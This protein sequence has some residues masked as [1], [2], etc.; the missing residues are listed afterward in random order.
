MKYFFLLLM[1]AC[2]SPKS[3][4][5]IDRELQINKHKVV[6]T[7]QKAIEFN[8]R[9]QVSRNKA[10]FE[11]TELSKLVQFKNEANPDFY[12]VVE[13]P[14]DLKDTV[15]QINSYPK[16]MYKGQ[17]GVIIPRVVFVDENYLPILMKPLR[18]GLKYQF[19]DGHFYSLE[20]TGN[21]LKGAKYAI[22]A[23]RNS[24]MGKKIRDNQGTTPT[25]PASEEIPKL[26]APLYGYPFG[27]LSLVIENQ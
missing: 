20:Y 22:V 5:Q 8:Q 1:I 13:L 12:E 6:T 3:V 4:K 25:V 7:Y 18:F 27:E 23:T 26:D 10:S 15:V 2:S 24:T 9:H 21:D 16:E 17:M 19:V 11:I 14:S